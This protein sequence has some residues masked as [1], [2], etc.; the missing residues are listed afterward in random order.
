MN[1]RQFL[2]ILSVGIGGIALS[3]F[4]TPN[5]PQN[6]DEAFE[7]TW[8]NTRTANAIPTKIMV[9]DRFGFNKG[10]LFFCENEV[11]RVTRVFNGGCGIE[12]IRS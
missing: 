9:T 8:S 11:L 6:I 10:D 1:R 4:I 2:K 3:K 5:R 12:V 7:D